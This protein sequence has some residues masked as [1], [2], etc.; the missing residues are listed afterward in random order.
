MSKHEL[1]VK[2]MSANEL[3]HKLEFYFDFDSRDREARDAIIEEL[4]NRLLTL[5]S[6]QKNL[7]VNEE[8][9]HK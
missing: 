3:L 8:G 5:E 6:L 2:E 7:A 4:K 9:E 1:N